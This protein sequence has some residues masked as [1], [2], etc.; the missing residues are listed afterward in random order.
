MS[1]SLSSIYDNNHTISNAVDNVIEC[2]THLLTA[3]TRGEIQPWLKIDLQ[4]IHDVKKVIIYNRQDCCGKY[5]M[6][7]INQFNFHELH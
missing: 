5:F 4:A 2:T 3:H 6:V 1:G 7:L